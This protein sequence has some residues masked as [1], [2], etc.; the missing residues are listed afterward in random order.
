MYCLRV[1]VVQGLDVG[2]IDYIIYIIVYR[3]SLRDGD[4]LL[5]EGVP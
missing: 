3:L 4:G 5:W 2:A 1:R